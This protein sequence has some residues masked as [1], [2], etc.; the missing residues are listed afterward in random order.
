MILRVRCGLAQALRQEA[1][2]VEGAVGDLVDLQLV[3]FDELGTGV[4]Q[5]GARAADVLRG[6][7]EVV[8]E[9][10]VVDQFCHQG[11]LPNAGHAA[12]DE[13]AR[14]VG[15]EEAVHRVEH[16]LPADEPAQLV[17][18]Q[19]VERTAQVG[20]P[21]LEVGVDVQLH[22]RDLGPFSG[23]VNP[24]F[25]RYFLITHAEFLPEWL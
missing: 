24:L 14:V 6:D 23:L 12:D 7:V 13:V 20:R 8:N 4:L 18:H 2:I 3:A 15:I 21:G 9:A 22:P 5:E 17:P 11:R 10:P 1:A 25:H 19:G 16:E